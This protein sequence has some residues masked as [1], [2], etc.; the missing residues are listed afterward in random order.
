MEEKRVFGLTLKEVSEIKDSVANW[1]DKNCPEKSGSDKGR[2]FAMSK[3]GSDNG[4]FFAMF[5]DGFNK[6]CESGFVDVFKVK[7]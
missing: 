1:T 7:D 3:D 4:G 2:Y 6:M 5:K